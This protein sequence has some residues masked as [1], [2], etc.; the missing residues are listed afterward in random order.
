M[1][2]GALDENMSREKFIRSSIIRS[3]DRHFYLQI[4]KTPCLRGKIGR[5]LDLNVARV[6]SGVIE[7]R[8]KRSGMNEEDAVCIP[9]N[10]TW[11]AWQTISRDLGIGND[12]ILSVFSPSLFG[13]IHVYSTLESTKFLETFDIFPE[14]IRWNSEGKRAYLASRY[15]GQEWIPKTLIEQGDEETWKNS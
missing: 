6:L 14:F 1:L 3:R 11:S 8:V 7:H 10:E 15:F 4:E 2:F 5:A 9:M 12:W 13:Q